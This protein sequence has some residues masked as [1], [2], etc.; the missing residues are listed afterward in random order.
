MKKLVSKLAQVHVARM[1][2][3]M[4]VHS[5][6]WAVRSDSRFCLLLPP[7]QA[8]ALDHLCFSYKACFSGLGLKRSRRELVQCVPGPAFHPQN[9]KQF[10]TR[11]G[12][13]L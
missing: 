5:L 1:K 13:W 3:D 10:L 8:V 4:K 7:E 11:S 12:Q 2:R 9:L 6:Q